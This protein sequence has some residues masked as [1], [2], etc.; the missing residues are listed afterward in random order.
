MVEMV[1]QTVERRPVE[2]P[3]RKIETHLMDEGYDEENRDEQDRTFLDVDHRR[4][5]V[6]V[7]PK[8]QN[9]IGSPDRH[10]TR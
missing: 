9:L 10:A 1:R 3:V 5:A 7:C 8:K 6:G 4:D 2:Q